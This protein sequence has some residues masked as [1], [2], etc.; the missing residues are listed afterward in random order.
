ML[1]RYLLVVLALL[2]ALSC[3]RNPDVA[4]RKYLESGNRYFE[5]KQYKEASIM[6]RQA[7]R[8]DPR[9]GEAYYRLGLTHLRLGGVPEAVH[10]LRRAVE[11]LPDRSEPK[12]ELGNIFLT[13][14]AV[15]PASNAQQLERLRNEIKTLAEHLPQNSP[16]RHRFL[17]YYYLSQRQMKEAIQEFREAHRLSPFRPEFTLPLVEA[18]LVEGPQEEGEKLARVFIEKNR[19]FLAGYDVLYFYYLRRNREAEAEGLLKQKVASNPKQARVWLQ[20][21]GHYHRL[22]RTAEMQAALEQLA[23][24]PKDFPEAYQLIGNFYRVRRDFDNAVR[25]YDLGIQ[26]DP[27][28]KALYQK[29]KAQALVDQGKVAEAAVLLDEV[30]KQNPKDD[31]ARAMRAALVVE[32]GTP[33]QVRAA[34]TELQAAVTRSP[35]NVVLRYHLGRALMRQGQI[36]QARTQFQEAIKRQPAYLAPRLSL[37]EVQLLKKDF[38]GA[39]QGVREVLQLDPANLQ[40]KLLRTS[41]L[42]GLGNLAQARADLE[43]TIKEHPGSREAQLQLAALN[44][45]ERRFKEAEDAFSKL[46]QASP[47]GDL[48]ALM[49][50]TE[51]YAAQG[52]FDKSIALL[53][54]EIAKDPNRPSLRLALANDYVRSGQYDAAIAE[55]QQL[56]QRDPKAGDLYLRLGETQR[57]KGDLQ[58]AVASFRKATELMPNQAQAFVVLALMLDQLKQFDQAVQVYEKVLQIEPDNPV[59]LNN[60]AYL[61]TE[62]GGDL[63][64]ALTLALRARQKLPQDPNIADTVGWIYIKK[65]LSDNAVEIFRDLVRKHPNNPTFHYHLGMALYQKGDRASARQALQTALRNKPSPEEASRIKE[66]LARVG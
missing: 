5:K 38:A 57:R 49:G 44:L 55:Y 33:E 61:L 40:A 58:A 29:L 39:L 54:A 59:A 42:V 31:D 48:R 56:I 43:S 60:L 63:D 62:R 25:Y 4:K 11:L 41:A 34:V 46:H 3:S 6:Y 17:G 22:K 66:L 65:N 53:K 10:A 45:H 47:A 16:H 36:D 50:L 7:L 8:K 15:T 51:T 1:A 9:Y 21:A 19:E 28:R 32:T 35:D 18:L 24:N 13:G 30:L 26:R 52:R 14:L 27:A 64:R 23:N 12:I 20:L 37:I 2:G